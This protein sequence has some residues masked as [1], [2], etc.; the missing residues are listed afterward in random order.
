RAT[1]VLP[2]RSAAPLRLTV[3]LRAA[4]LTYEAIAVRRAPPRQHHV[5]VLGLGHAG[6][7][8]RHLLEA[9]AVGRA[10]F[11]QKVDVPALGD[12]P[13]QVALEYG[14]LL[15]LSHRPGVEVRPLAGF[16]ARAILRAHQAHAELIEPVTFARLVSVEDGGSW[17]VA[18]RLLESH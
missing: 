16:E 9:P 6:H 11:G 1:S 13:V 2:P 4:V 12:G 14:A 15:R 7:A 8:R 5:A 18:V 17:D 3:R 10:A